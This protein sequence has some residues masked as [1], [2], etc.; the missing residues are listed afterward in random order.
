MHSIGSLSVPTLDVRVWSP[1]GVGCAEPWS[2]EP[3]DGAMTRAFPGPSQ[4]NPK[5]A[6]SWNSADCDMASLNW[7]PWRPRNLSTSRTTP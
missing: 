6:H 5:R 4:Q 1:Y 2:A 3:S 7:L